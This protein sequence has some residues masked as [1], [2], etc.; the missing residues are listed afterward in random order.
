[1]ELGLAALLDKDSLAGKDVL[2]VFEAQ[3]P[4]CDALRRKH[5]VNASLK[6][7]GRSAAHHKRADAVLV[8]EGANT[9]AGDHG[10]RSPG[11]LASRVGLFQG[12]ENI[13]R[14]HTSLAGLVEGVGK[15]VQH[16]FA[17]RVGVYMAVRLLV[18]VVPEFGSVDEVSVVRETDA[19][20]GVDIEWLAL[21]AL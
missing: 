17:I 6:S 5:V 18:E 14:V 20:G 21:G 19:V 1:M 16:Q 13:V 15:D 3:L 11:T 9:E 4:E 2:K 12:L 8:A 10:C 7:S